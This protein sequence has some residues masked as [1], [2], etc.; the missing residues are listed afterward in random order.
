MIKERNIALA[1]IFSIVTCGIYGL[2]WFVMLTDETKEVVND[3]KTASGV[4]ALVLTIVTCNIYGWY[5]AYKLGERVDYMKQSRGQQS[6]NT[7]ILFIILQ[8]L[9]LGIVNYIVAQAELNRH[10]TPAV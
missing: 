10:A 4:L 9:G 5:W 2:Y 6:S 3:Q 1:I 7:G 8:A